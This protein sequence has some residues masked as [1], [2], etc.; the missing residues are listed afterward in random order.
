MQKKLCWLGMAAEEK[1]QMKGQGEIVKQK[2]GK[3]R[4]NCIKNGVKYFEIAYFLVI[5][6]K[7]YR[8]GTFRFSSVDIFPYNNYIQHTILHIKITRGP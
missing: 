2:E 4:K 8:L 7:N 1:I 5:N 3:K 6:A